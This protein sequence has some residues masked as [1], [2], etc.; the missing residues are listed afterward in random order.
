VGIQGVPVRVK[1]TPNRCLMQ[2]VQRDIR[3]ETKSGG[4]RLERKG[5]GGPLNLRA[6]W[7]RQMISIN[8]KK[9]WGGKIYKKVWGGERGGGMLEG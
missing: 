9:I 8:N 1:G 4:P 3:K 7:K 5:T 6:D 2:H